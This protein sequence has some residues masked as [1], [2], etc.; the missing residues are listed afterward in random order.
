MALSVAALSASERKGRERRITN[1]KCEK[2]KVGR[3]EER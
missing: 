3:G 2:E 1:R